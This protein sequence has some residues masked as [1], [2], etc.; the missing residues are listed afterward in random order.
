MP[1]ARLV[2]TSAA[3]VRAAAC[4]AVGHCQVE[5]A[6]MCTQDPVGSVYP[7]LANTH[8][9]THTHADELSNVVQVAITQ[10]VCSTMGEK[11]VQPP[12]L[13]FAEIHRQSTC[14]TP[15]VFVLSPGADPAYDLFRLGDEMGFKPG[16]KLKYMAL[17]QG[18]GPR[19]QEA[20]ESGT[21]PASRA[22]CGL[23][24]GCSGCH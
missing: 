12:L 19:A 15:I 4:L 13:D 5:V 8:T 22:C 20:I 16:T 21:L 7:T 23:Q 17:G 2:I 18:M 24:L 10:Y 14:L 6:Y 9:H 1:Q 3:P 11:Y